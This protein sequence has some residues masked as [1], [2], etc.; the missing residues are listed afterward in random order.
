[1]A[2][3]TTS[4]SKNNQPAKKRLKRAFSESSS[5]DEASPLERVPK[6]RDDATKF[7]KNTPPPSPPAVAMEMSEDED[8]VTEQKQIDMEGINDEIVEAVITQLQNTGNR[9]HLVK[10]LATVLMRQLKI[11]QQFVSPPA[12]RPSL[13]L[14][15]E[16]SHSILLQIC[17]PVRHRILAVSDIPQEAGVVSTLA[18]SARKGARVGPPAPYLLL[19]DNLPAETDTGPRSVVVVNA[20][21]SQPFSQPFHHHAKPVQRGVHLGRRRV[22]PGKAA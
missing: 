10:E 22:G 13:Q 15:G 4:P 3:P 2:S 9:P 21:G 1:M 5:S 12:P 8:A 6:R 20:V 17:E 7:Q 11:V 19:P 16:S 18:L 14:Y